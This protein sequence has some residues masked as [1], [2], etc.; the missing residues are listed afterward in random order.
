MVARSGWGG[1]SLV[2]AAELTYLRGEVSG[3]IAVDVAARRE[4]VR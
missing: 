3:Q 2:M 1:S 4:T